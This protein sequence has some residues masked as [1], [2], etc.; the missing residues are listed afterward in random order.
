ILFKPYQPVELLDQSLSV[1]DVHWASLSPQ[2]EGL[3]VPSKTYGVLAAGRPLLFIGAIDGE[4]GQLVARHSCGQTFQPGDV[5][6]VVQWLRELSEDQ[7]RLHEL[8]NNAR[9]L[10]QHEFSYGVSL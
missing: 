8:G 10:Y 4:I 6:G 1:P 7:T 9:A 2:L 3:I 5:E